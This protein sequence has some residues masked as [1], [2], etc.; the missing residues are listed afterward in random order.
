MSVALERRP[1]PVD[2]DPDGERFRVQPARVG[3]LQLQLGIRETPATWLDYGPTSH[4]D[5][6]LLFRGYGLMPTRQEEEGR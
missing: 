3:A 4:L 6:S 5:E 1:P 2:S